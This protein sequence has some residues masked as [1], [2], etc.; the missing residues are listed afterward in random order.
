[1]KQNYF[2]LIVLTAFLLFANAG[3]QAQALIHWNAIG[4]QTTNPAR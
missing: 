4:W 2:K 3:A 1:M